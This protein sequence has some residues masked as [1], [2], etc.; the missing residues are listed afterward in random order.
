MSTSFTVYQWRLGGGIFES[1]DS[2]IFLRVSGR[3]SCGWK[4]RK[5]CQG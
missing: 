1:R 2:Q 3:V 5:K 4:S